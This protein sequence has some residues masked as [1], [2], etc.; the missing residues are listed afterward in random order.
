MKKILFIFFTVFPL[1]S[2]SEDDLPTVNPSGLY[3]TAEG[4]ELDEISGT[5]NAPLQAHFS[6]N[7]SNVG[8]YSARYEWKIWKEDKGTELIVHRFDEEIDHTFSESGSY[9]IQ[10]YATFVLGNDTVA[11][12]LEGAEN[13]ITFS[14]STSKL[15]FPNAFSP[16]GDGYNDVLKP[17]DGYQSIVSFEAAVFNRWGS[18]LYSWD[19]LAGGWD[20]TCNGKTVRDGV[21]FLVVSAK[22][23]DGRKYHFRKTITVLTNNNE[24]AVRGGGMGG[25]E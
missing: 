13:P 5:Q 20:G 7:P 15:D 4:E 14:I 21:Y 24:D 19:D 25:D 9:R 11:Y 10:L 23:A 12:P 17:K 1:F 22:G 3:I 8:L 16:N 18:K 2:F 6:A